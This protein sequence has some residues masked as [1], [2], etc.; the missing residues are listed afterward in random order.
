VQAQRLSTVDADVVKPRARK[1]YE[2]HFQGK[3]P[4]PIAISKEVRKTLKRNIAEPG[5]MVFEVARGIVLAQLQ[6]Y[7]ALFKATDKYSAWIGLPVVAPAVRTESGGRRRASSLWSRSKSSI[8]HAD[9]MAIGAPE[10]FKHAVHVDQEFNW[11]G[12]MSPATQF[13]QKEK[14]GEGAY[15]KVYKYQ[16]RDSDF[17]IAIKILRVTEKVEEVMREIEILKVLADD[18]IVRYY[19][20]YSQANELWI[21][22]DYCEGGSAL[23]LLRSIGRPLGEE[24]VAAILH[25]V[26][27]GLQYLHSKD[28]IHRDIKAGNVLLGTDG[29]AKLADFGVSSQLEESNGKTAS[30]K[31]TPLWMAPEVLDG[32]TSYSL[33][34]DVWSLGITAI[35][36]AE[37][38]PPLMD[39]HLMRAMMHILT[40][41][42]PSLSQPEAWS[43]PF[44]EFVGACLQKEPSLRPA[45]ADIINHPFLASV[46]DPTAVVKKLVDEAR[47]KA[48]K[49]PSN[50]RAKEELR[51]K[52]AATQA[53]QQGD[54]E[55]AKAAA[56][57]VARPTPTEQEELAA[58]A[59]ALKAA[60][61]A[62]LARG[63]QREKQLKKAK[64]AEAELEERLAKADRALRKKEAELQQRNVLNTRLKATIKDLEKAAGSP[65]A[66]QRSPRQSSKLRRTATTS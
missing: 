64:K 28:I 14:L 55:S 15:G 26:V 36:L 11:S 65:R 29:K 50:G 44:V 9:S 5:P 17:T 53:R 3:A 1:L 35:E 21:L 66:A 31:G 43:D 47:S 42:P 63:Q 56:A 58:Y 18:T 45:P 54:A 62:E 20:S 12:E 33:K 51:L 24:E 38:K 37:G 8:A 6:D 2:Q 61:K 19:G 25:F 32:A 48:A 49:K 57:L 59:A 46:A 41:E 10:G 27:R 40:E 52:E 4:Q 34:A 13:E 23:D 30:N 16:Q 39:M 22:M 7:F 60:L